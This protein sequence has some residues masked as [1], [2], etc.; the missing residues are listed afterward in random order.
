MEI[1]RP[2]HGSRMLEGQQIEG[3]I[4]RP[5]YRKIDWVECMAWQC[6][7]VTDM[8]IRKAMWL[9]TYDSSGDE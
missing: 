7:T 8:D 5:A 4:L 3:L 9:V 1:E 6:S 2:A